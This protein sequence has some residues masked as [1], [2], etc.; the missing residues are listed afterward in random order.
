M[1]NPAWVNDLFSSI[2]EMNSDKFTSFFTEDGVFAFGNIPPVNGKK[3][4]FEM[5]DGFFKS[6]KGIK[7]SNLQSYEVPAQDTVITKGTV[8][9]IRHNDTELTVDFCNVFAMQD[10]KIGHYRIYIDNSELYN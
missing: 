2:D 4:V 9:Y 1:A 8:T 10:N 3:Q 7:H 5:V 6:I